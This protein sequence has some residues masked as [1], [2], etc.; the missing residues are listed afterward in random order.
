M[1]EYVEVYM[2]WRACV[3]GV[4]VRAVALCNPIVVVSVTVLHYV[5]RLAL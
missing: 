2:Q 5:S 1:H 4:Q 3:S